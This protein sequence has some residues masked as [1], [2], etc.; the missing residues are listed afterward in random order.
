MKDYV[1]RAI[2][3]GLEEIGFSDHMPVM[4]EPEF[5][6]GYDEL[7]KYINKVHELQERY[8]GHIAIRL[9]CEMDFVND[10]IDEIRDIIRRYRFDYVIGSIH[11]L[12]GWPFDQEQY[13]DD[14]EKNDIDAIYERFY[15]EIICL[16]E[17]GLYDIAGHID[18]IKC[19][20]YRSEENL[21]Y[22][23]ERVASV[24][25]SSDL[26]VEV[27]TGGFDKPCME[28]YPSKE[29]LSILRHYEIPVTVGSDAHRP[30]DVG[31]YYNSALALLEETGYDHIMYFKDRKRIPKPLQ[32]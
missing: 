29:F 23:Y 18:N 20:G 8:E 15:D 22:N 32:S 13:S 28:Q 4:P 16:A 5:C 2:E 31:R 10:R 12:N 19:M 21:T 17:P 11:Y 25:K 9:G 26:A 3:I 27:N 14:F 30:Q 7:P 6:M 1:K 24:L